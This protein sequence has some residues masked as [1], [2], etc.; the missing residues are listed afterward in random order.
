MQ[1]S[2]NFV[3]ID[4]ETANYQPDSAC[5]VGLVKVVGGEIVSYGGNWVTGVRKAA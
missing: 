2:M 5:A 4:F 1:G 3:A